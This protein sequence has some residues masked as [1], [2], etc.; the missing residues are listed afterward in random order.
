[1]FEKSYGGSKNFVFYSAKNGFALDLIA[2][3]LYSQLL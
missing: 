3:L 2:G 1:M